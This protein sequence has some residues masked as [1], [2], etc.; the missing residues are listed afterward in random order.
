MPN[1]FLDQFLDAGIKPEPGWSYAEEQELQQT[2]LLD[3]L[4]SLL[5]TKSMKRRLG[6]DATTAELSTDKKIAK[7]VYNRLLT[8]YMVW[9]GEEANVTEKYAEISSAK[10]GTKARDLLSQ[11][12]QIDWDELW[13]KEKA[14]LALR[15][16]FVANNAIANDQ[17]KIGN[18]Y[19]NRFTNE[20]N[21]LGDVLDPVDTHRDTKFES[22]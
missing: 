8:I 7:Q 19:A 18:I 6:R 16:R 2:R 13:N 21:A 10:R 15:V 11:G 14:Y 3:L 1:S 9:G 4:V 12:A 5:H 17:R 20:Y 22:I